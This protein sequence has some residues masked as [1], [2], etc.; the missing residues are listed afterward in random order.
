MA[1]SAQEQLATIPVV[2]QQSTLMT[3]RFR[4]W[5][6]T[7]LKRHTYCQGWSAGDIVA[8]LAT[9]AD[10]YTAVISAGLTDEP[11]LPWGA[12]SLDDVR[13]IRTEAVSRLLS[14]GTD[15]LINGFERAANALQ[16][17][18]D[19]LQTAD[20]GKMAWH[21]RGPIPIGCWI[22]MRLTELVLH[23]WD[24]R[25]PHEA[26]PHLSPAA[27]PAV[28]TSLPEMQLRFLEQRLPAAG[29]EGVHALHAGDQ[30]W[31]F[32]RQEQTISYQNDIPEQVTTRLHTDMESMILLTLGRV[33][34]SAKLQ[35]KTCTM[36]GDLA[37]ARRFY[38]ALFTP[39]LSSSATPPG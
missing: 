4:D 22:G 11:A 15:T 21:P 39:Y 14:D 34:Y 35:D 24:I 9:G 31:A 16:V 20:L 25:Q 12:K 27:A 33:G 10:F 17:V 7:Y 26:N 28:L 30:S 5:P 23:D 18:F 8:H 32:L 19:A 38:T 3:K 13:T 29:C 36:T 37:V 6:H 1:F 2:A